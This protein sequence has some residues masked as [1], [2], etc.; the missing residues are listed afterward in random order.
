MDVPA[1][2]PP[3]R[4]S[5]PDSFPAEDRP[6]AAPAKVTRY[7]IPDPVTPWEP[8]PWLEP[9]TEPDQAQWPVPPGGQPGRRPKRKWRRKLLLALVAPLIL[10]QLIAFMF[11]LGITLPRTAYMLKAGEPVIYQFV[12]INHINRR[13]LAATIAHEDEQLGTRSGAFDLGEFQARA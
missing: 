7:P 8:T 6:E 9:R 4:S 11:S 10:A 3:P 5:P 12:S 13:L 1:P 2:A